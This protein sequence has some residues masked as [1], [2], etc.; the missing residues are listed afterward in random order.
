MNVPVDRQRLI[1]QGKLLMNDQKL[2][3]YKVG[4][5]SDLAETTSWENLVSFHSHV[6]GT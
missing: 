4:F 5:P 1:F 3:T 2:S 6:L